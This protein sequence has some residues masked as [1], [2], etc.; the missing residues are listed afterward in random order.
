MYAGGSSCTIDCAVGIVRRW[1]IDSS[2]SVMLP[3]IDPLFTFFGRSSAVSKCSAHL[4]P[5]E[6]AAVLVSEEVRSRRLK[7]RGT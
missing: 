2:H 6:G 3:L 4:P 7:I 1:G 5:I